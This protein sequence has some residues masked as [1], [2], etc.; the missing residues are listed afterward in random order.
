MSYKLRAVLHGH[1]ADVKDVEASLTSTGALISASRDKT[2]KLWLP[3]ENGYSLRRTFKGHTKYVSCVTSME[4]SEE[5]PSGLILTGCQDGKVRGYLPD[6]EDPLFQLDGHTENVTSLYLSKFGTLISGSWDKTAKVWFNRKCTMTLTGHDLAVWCVAILPGVGLMLTGSADRTIRI[7]KTG[8]C[9]HVLKGHTDAVRGLA[10]LSSE[11][12]LSCSNDATV[13]RWSTAGEC[14][15]TYY[16]HDNYIYSISL[17]PNGIDWVT[18]GEDR[19]MRVWENNAVVQTVFLP[20][21]SVWSVSALPNGD[22]ATA[23]SDGVIRVFTKDP[24]RYGSAEVQSLFE[25]EL[26]KSSLAAQQELGG[27]KVSDLPG[28]EALYEPGRKDGQTK[29]VRSGDKVSVHSW[30]MAEQKW[31]KIGDVVGA[32]GGSESTS[33]KKLYQGKEYDYVFDIEID[34][35]KST[36]K[37]PF[38][39]SDDPYMAAQKFIHKH[40]LSQYYLE[41]IANHIVKNTGGQ[42]LGLDAGGNADPLT[43][44][45]SYSAGG[46]QQG[47]VSAGS[48]VDP[49]TG[50]GAYVSGGGGA[51]EG[52]DRRGA[53]PPDPWMQGAYRTEEGMDTTENCSNNAAPNP[54]FPQTNFLRFDQALRPDAMISKL[55]EF[56]QQVEENQRLAEAE[57]EAMP[58]LALDAADNAQGVAGLAMPLDWPD[59]KVFPVLDLV[60]LI[61]LHPH[62]QKHILQKEFLDKLFSVCLKHLDKCSPPPNQMLALRILTNLFSTEQGEDFLL[63]YRDSVM[64]RIFE[65]LFPVVNDN[66]NIQVAAATVMLNYSVSLSKRPKEE[67]G[68]VQALSIL[69]VNF[70]AF[71][72]DWEARFRT[73]VSI[74]TLLTASKD[75][76]EYAKTLDVRE[77]V[78]GWKVLEGPDKCTRCAEFIIN[79]L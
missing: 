18:S 51:G 44:G 74:G 34:E 75:N 19:S 66:K 28:P 64:S 4:P 2:A 10:I 7:W 31:S 14:L 1:S 47:T 41:E 63:M 72:L 50:S 52:Q 21:I 33:G 49:F 69:G 16:G 57:L 56:N 6:V 45:Y 53:P 12:F 76:L 59:Q 61:L 70:I 79:M 11:H 15:G 42:T 73:L 67:D 60:R 13:R 8:T 35:P 25:D 9:E 37:L 38:N 40:D 24:E 17:L 55:K 36:L 26:S 30:S 27:V 78:R 43:G 77:G 68:Q 3:I 39:V 29:M 23:S 48:A 71:I 20:A 65:G 58:S 62:N 54:Y 32:A 22:V 46:L 5:F